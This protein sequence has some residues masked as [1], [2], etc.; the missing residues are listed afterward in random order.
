MLA[1][2]SLIFIRIKTQLRPF[3]I[4]IPGPAFALGLSCPGLL[5]ITVVTICIEEGPNP[6][7][8]AVEERIITNIY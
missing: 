2:L 7:E 5:P 8:L 3:V 4:S 1:V 6:V